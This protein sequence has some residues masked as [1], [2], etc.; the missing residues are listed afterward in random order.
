MPDKVREPFQDTIRAVWDGFNEIDGFNALV[1]GAG[2][3]WRQA[4]VLRAYAKYM[5]Q[6]N[7]PF[8]VDYIEEA[9][10]GNTDITRLLVQLFEARF[11]PGR[12][13]LAA[14]AEARTA[15]VERDHARASSG[16]STTSPA[17]TTTAS[18]APT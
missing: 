1:L 11:D 3:T 6:G 16:R 2:L 8:A 10:R 4:T 17:S 5:K 14:D 18:C 13:G 9:L 15:R 12:N 7:S